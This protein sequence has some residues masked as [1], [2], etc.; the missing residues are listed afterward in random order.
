VV[1]SVRDLNGTEIKFHDVWNLSAD[2][3]T[4]TINS[5]LIVPQGEVDLTLVFDK[6]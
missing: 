5:H 4:L 6:Q 2:G 1:D 3:K